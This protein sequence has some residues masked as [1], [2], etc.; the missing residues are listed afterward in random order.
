M[1]LRIP[2]AEALGRRA[3]DVHV[4]QN[5]EGTA[6]D[7][8]LRSF[9]LAF[10]HLGVDEVV[11]LHP[12]T[13]L[14]LDA[15]QLARTSARRITRALRTVVQVRAVLHDA[16][17]GKLIELT[18]AVSGAPEVNGSPGGS[19]GWSGRSAGSPGA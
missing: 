6:T 7:D 8:A 2:A 5:A 10:H 15:A 11:V 3:E 19:S 16:Q 18:Q 12:G 9:E 1:T 17:T 13:A 4:V 14:D